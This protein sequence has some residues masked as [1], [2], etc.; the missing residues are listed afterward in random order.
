MNSEIDV[1]Y[2]QSIWLVVS[3]IV[4]MHSNT[5][6]WLVFFLFQV[7]ILKALDEECAISVKAMPKQ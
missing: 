4:I 1:Y 5:K 7:T 3:S 2:A 6:K